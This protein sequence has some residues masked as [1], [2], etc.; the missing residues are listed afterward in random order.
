MLI[1]VLCSVATRMC[2]YTNFCRMQIEIQSFSERKH[3]PAFSKGKYLDLFSQQ[4]VFCFEPVSG[5]DQFLA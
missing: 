3:V 1:F 2:G 5:K 4:E